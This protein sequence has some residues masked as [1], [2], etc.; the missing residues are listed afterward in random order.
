M[1]SIWRRGSTQNGENLIAKSTRKRE[2]WGLAKS[3]FYSHMEVMVQ[4]KYHI[5][6]DTFEINKDNLRITLADDESVAYS[7]HYFVIE[8]PDDKGVVVF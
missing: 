3:T 7:A 1:Q 6:Y 5:E 2:A 8:I 4:H